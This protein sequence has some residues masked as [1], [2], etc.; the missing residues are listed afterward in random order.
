MPCSAFLSPSSIKLCLE[1]LQILISSDL[2]RREATVS[3]YRDALDEV[4][5]CQKGLLRNKHYTYRLEFLDM[6]GTLF[7]YHYHE[8]GRAMRD[9]D[10]LIQYVRKLYSYTW[11]T[12]SRADESI[13]NAQRHLG[14]VY[15]IK[16]IRNFNANDFQHDLEWDSTSCVFKDWHVYSK[17][18]IELDLVI[19]QGLAPPDVEAFG[20]SEMMEWVDQKYRGLC[21]T[22]K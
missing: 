8:D 16:A 18:K 2:G 10:T 9:L 17:D 3:F 13:L 6:L 4:D 5:Q 7:S 21:I 1:E 12:G 11:M 14:W 22:G 20:E 19:S 15:G